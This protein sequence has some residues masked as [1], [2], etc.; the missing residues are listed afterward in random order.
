VF[1]VIELVWWWVLSFFLNHT[2]IFIWWGLPLE[3]TNQKGDRF[4]VANLCK[5][6]E[7]IMMIANA[8]ADHTMTKLP[9]LVLRG[10]FPP[11]I[12]WTAGVIITELRAYMRGAYGSGE[13][14]AVY[15]QRK[16]YNSATWSDLAN[17]SQGPNSEAD[18]STTLSHTVDG[19]YAYRLYVYIDHPS[20][21]G[22]SYDGFV[23]GVRLAYT[24]SQ[25]LP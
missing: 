22:G 23:R 4:G 18:V 24:V 21:G 13:V 16:A 15:L 8:S 3:G 25:P 7:C 14:A 6:Y 17:I 1:C 10:V 9:N 20:S 19:S 12:H 5:G 2:T 11:S